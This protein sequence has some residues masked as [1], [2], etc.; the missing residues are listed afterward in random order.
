MPA[1]KRRR[2]VN[3]NQSKAN[4]FFKDRETIKDSHPHIVE[5]FDS[6]PG[7]AVQ[8]EIIENCFKKENKTWKLDLEK[9][10][11]RES[12]KRCV[13]IMESYMEF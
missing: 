13:Y 10:F 4:K 12:K 6:N 7:R 5:W 1:A 3:R 11:F 2:S 9:P 8:T